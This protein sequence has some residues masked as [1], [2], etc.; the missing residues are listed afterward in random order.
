MAKFSVG[1]NVV[2]RKDAP[3]TSVNA[4]DYQQSQ[5][6]GIV[7]VPMNHKFGVTVSFSDDYPDE[8]VQEEWLDLYIAALSSDAPAGTGEIAPTMLS[9]GLN[10]RGR[11]DTANELADLRR[12]NAALKKQNAAYAASQDKVQK[13]LTGEGA[14]MSPRPEVNLKFL[15]LAIRRSNIDPE[16]H[17]D[18]KH[19]LETAIVALRRELEEAKDRFHLFEMAVHEDENKDKDVI[20][21]LREQVAALI[22]DRLRLQRRNTALEDVLREI[23]GMMHVEPAEYAAALGR[24][25]ALAFIALEGETS[26][27]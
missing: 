26:N 4:K 12:E 13:I 9:N 23:W 19:R 16:E 27:A 1:D 17:N 22:A 2:I 8:Y 14:D 5:M 7:R 25:T 18:V 15:L 11:N 6:V 3:V 10:W 21:D 24:A 20:L